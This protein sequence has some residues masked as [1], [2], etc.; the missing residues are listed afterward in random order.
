MTKLSEFKPDERPSRLNYVEE[1]WTTLRNAR[2]NTLSRA[3]NYLFVLNTGGLLASLSYIT[4]NTNTAN[5]R[6]SIVL[7]SLGILFSALHAALDYYLVEHNFFKYRKNV[8][9]LYGDKLDWEA[10]VDSIKINNCGELLLHLLGWGGVIVFFT[11]LYL[12]LSKLY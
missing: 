10:F 2:E 5:I 1:H 12:G 3:T 7:F 6:T 9:K 8:N 11:G 4:S